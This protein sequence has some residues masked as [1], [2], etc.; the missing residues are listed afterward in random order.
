MSHMGAR[1]QELGPSSALFLGHK[2]GVGSEAEQL[3]HVLALMWDADIIGGKSACCTVPLRQ[4][5]FFPR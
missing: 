1:S 5:H 3:G 4:P 2:Q